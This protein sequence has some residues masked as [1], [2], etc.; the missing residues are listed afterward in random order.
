MLLLF[1]FFQN[2]SSIVTQVSQNSQ[3]EECQAN[4][5]I[6]SSYPDM[7]QLGSLDIPQWHLA[8]QVCVEGLYMPGSA[9]DRAGRAEMDTIRFQ[10]QSAEPRGDEHG[11]GGPKVL[12]SNPSSAMF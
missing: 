5:A 1:F 9:V 11:L 10:H 7:G 4:E 12:L 8:Q 6:Y 3:L 2:N